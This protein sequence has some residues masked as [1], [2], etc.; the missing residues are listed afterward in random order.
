MYQTTVPLF[1]PRNL[2]FSEP[3]NYAMSASKFRRFLI[4]AVWF[5]VVAA[6]VQ[7]VHSLHTHGILTAPFRVY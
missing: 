4:E 6:L 3:D 1:W 5:L 7:L 2:R